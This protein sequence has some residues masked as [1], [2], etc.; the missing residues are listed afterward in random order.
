MDDTDSTLSPVWKEPLKYQREGMGSQIYTSEQRCGGYRSRNS[1]A[2]F[3][4]HATTDI[5]TA[6]VC[7]NPASFSQKKELTPFDVYAMPVAM[8]GT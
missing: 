1:K 3:R 8:L 7:P 6:G 2:A 4:S 5:Y